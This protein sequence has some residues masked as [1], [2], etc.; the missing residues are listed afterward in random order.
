MYALSASQV[1]RER[2]LI[3]SERH[4]MTE[5]Q[6][7]LH[8]LKQAAEIMGCSVDHLRG[9]H[10]AGRIAFLQGPRK[11]VIADAELDRYIDEEL[12]SVTPRR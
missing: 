12:K 7:K 8:S 10:A 5:P 2:V 1:R 4:A 3:E 9:E 6:R 11:Y